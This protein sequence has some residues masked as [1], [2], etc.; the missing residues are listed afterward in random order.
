MTVVALI[1]E[2]LI[3][4]L[5]L[6]K[7]TYA[8]AAKEDA[9]PCFFTAPDQLI[10]MHNKVANTELTSVLLNTV[11]LIQQ[12][13][14]MYSL[15]LELKEIRKVLSAVEILHTHLL[16]SATSLYYLEK[17]YKYIGMLRMP[18]PVSLRAHMKMVFV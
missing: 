11:R 5:M 8:E 17:Y 10:H 18:L 6:I 13:L 14:T 12:T 7:I 16:H 1:S 15:D 9:R 3:I 4:L 2:I